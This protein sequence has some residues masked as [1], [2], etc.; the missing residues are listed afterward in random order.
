HAPERLERLVLCNTAPYFGPREVFEARI[1]AVRRDG[2]AGLVEGILERWFTPAFRAADPAVVE[3]V[4]AMLL[5]TPEE[6]YAACCAALRDLDERGN[7]GRI[8]VPT[9]VITGSDDPSSPP[10]A[11]LALA[12]AI[13]GARC[14]EL[15]AAHLSN[16]G[17]ATAF[18]AAVLGFLG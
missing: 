18:N 11:G 6:G 4:R 1:E 15:P 9:L 5:A 17:A 12:A 16:L 3:R 10:A 13:P 2:L 7:L 14:I 8:S